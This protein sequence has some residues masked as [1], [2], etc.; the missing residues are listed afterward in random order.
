MHK[1]LMITNFTIICR[2]TQDKETIVSL[3]GAPTVQV[4]MKIL[5]LRQQMAK[6]IKKKF[7]VLQEN[8]RLS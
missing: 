4:I 2:K 1:K 8:L 7:H 3:I 6:T 5:N